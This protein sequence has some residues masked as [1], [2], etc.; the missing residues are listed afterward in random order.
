MPYELG[1]AQTNYMIFT[2]PNNEWMQPFNL[3]LLS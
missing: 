2:T 1:S 3:F